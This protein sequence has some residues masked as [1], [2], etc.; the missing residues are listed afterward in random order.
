MALAIRGAAQ[1]RQEHKAN[2]WPDIDEWA[3]PDEKG[4]FAAPRTLPLLLAL[5][6]SKRISGGANPSSVYL[7]LLSR[8]YGDGVVEMTRDEEHAFNS[9]YTGNRAARSWQERMEIL[10]KNGFIR[11]VKINGH[12]KY[13]LIVHPTDLVHKLRHEGRV[14]SDLWHAYQARQVEVR[15][16]TYEEREKARAE[17]SKTKK[18]TPKSKA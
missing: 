9:G 10:E 12:H 17:I 2:Y 11:S 4:W 6:N 5:M 7:E 14:D 13:V 8:T 1:R 3:G 16:T 18:K 15:E